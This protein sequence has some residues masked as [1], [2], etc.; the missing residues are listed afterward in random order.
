MGRM[1]ELV[2]ARHGEILEIARS[3]RVISMAVFGSAARGDGTEG[4]DIDF[5][6]EMEDGASL[7][8]LGGLQFELSELLGTEVDLVTRGG[9]K[10][11]DTHILDEAVPL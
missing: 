9:L 3:H 5:L 2:A 8:D 10:D 11:R 1:K 4:S 6:V 7:F